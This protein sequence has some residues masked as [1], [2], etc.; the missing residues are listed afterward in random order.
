MAIFLS[1]LAKGLLAQG[2]R[3]AATNTLKNTAK[4]KIKSKA[5]D[6][7]KNRKKKGKER[8]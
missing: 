6:F 4:D 7:I 3:K 8:V 1:G 5:N 2:A